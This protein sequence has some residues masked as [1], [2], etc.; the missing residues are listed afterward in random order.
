MR[1]ATA[2]TLTD[3]VP[4]EDEAGEDTYVGED[5]TEKDCMQGLTSGGTDRS[6]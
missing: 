4:D 3:H 6:V 2:K 1:D 5:M